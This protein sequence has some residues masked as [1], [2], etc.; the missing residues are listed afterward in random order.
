MSQKRGE[1]VADAKRSDGCIQRTVHDVLVKVLGGTCPHGQRPVKRERGMRRIRGQ[2]SY[3]MDFHEKL[4]KLGQAVQT[5][6]EHG[7]QLLARAHSL[8]RR[9]LFFEVVLSVVNWFLKITPAEGT[10][11]LIFI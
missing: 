5:E 9:K 11:I 2:H 7:Y 4:G 3:R 1:H 10:D 6:Q 8:K